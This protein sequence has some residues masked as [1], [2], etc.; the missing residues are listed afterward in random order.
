LHDVWF[1]VVQPTF[2]KGPG[3]QI[4]QVT[5]EHIREAVRGAGLASDAEID[6]V[7]A[8]LAAFAKNPQTLMSLPRIFQ[9]WGI[10]PSGA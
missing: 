9:V 3:K 6:T 5:M 1:N 2:A 8:D 4:A 7:I 10:N